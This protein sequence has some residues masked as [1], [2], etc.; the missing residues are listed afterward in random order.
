MIV[1]E[2]I[3]KYSV[4]T[5]YHAGLSVTATFG[6]SCISFELHFPMLSVVMKSSRKSGGPMY[7][8]VKHQCS[9]KHEMSMKNIISGLL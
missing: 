6:P 4:S 2:E 5:V 1:A 3:S 9:A 8:G 7:F